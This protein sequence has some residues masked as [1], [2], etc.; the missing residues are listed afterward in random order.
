EGQPVGVVPVQVTEEDGT[1]KWPAVQQ[2]AQPLQ[3]GAGIEHEPGG[4]PVLS[5]RYA[6]GISA[7]SH[8]LRTG[9]WCGPPDSA[10]EQSH[11]ASLR[12]FPTMAFGKFRQGLSVAMTLAPSSQ[13]ARLRRKP[14]IRLIT[15]DSMEERGRSDAER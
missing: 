14:S 2:R 7:V 8:E 1:A 12:F 3:A 5:Q 13:F 10:D 9:R 15:L 4:L 11:R 6:G